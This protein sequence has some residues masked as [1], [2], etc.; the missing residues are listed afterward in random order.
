MFL[1]K[2]HQRGPSM[3]QSQKQVA[4]YFCTHLERA[5]YQTIAQIAAATGVS[6]TT[7]V[8]LAYALDFPSFSEMQR[9]IRQELLSGT[10]NPDLDCPQK[11]QDPYGYLLRHEVD[12]LQETLRLLDRQSMD[13]AVSMLCES[14]RVFL[15]GR[16]SSTAACLWFQSNASQIRGNIISIRDLADLVDMTEHS[17]ALVVSYHPYAKDTIHMAKHLKE[18]GCR[19]IALTDGHLSPLA[20]LADVLLLTGSAKSEQSFCNAITGP[21]AVMNVLLIG[22]SNKLPEAAER[23]RRS[24]DIHKQFNTVTELYL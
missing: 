16:R 18:R 5:S 3:P 24:R 21:V 13:K 14:D 8:R 11:E 7:V 19:I 9:T 1:E 2:L 22:M 6:E 4:A 12:S 10:A 20:Q 17:T 15:L 23:L